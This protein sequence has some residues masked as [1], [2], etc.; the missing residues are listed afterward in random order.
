MGS[1]GTAF[2]VV[3]VSTERVLADACIAVQKQREE[4]EKVEFAQF[5]KE[6]PLI[7]E[8]FEDLKRQ[9]GS[10]SESEWKA[11]PEIGDYTVKRRKRFETFSAVSDNLLAGAPSTGHLAAF[12][13][14]CMCAEKCSEPCALQRLACCYDALL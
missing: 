11:I 4:R 1:H 7:K 5:R 13:G 9:L 3:R 10:V 6:N 14:S 8:Q 12:D 2:R